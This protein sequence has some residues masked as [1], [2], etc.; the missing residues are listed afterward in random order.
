MGKKIL[1]EK[2][3]VFRGFFSRIFLL[4]LF[5]HEDDARKFPFFFSWSNHNFHSDL[6]GNCPVIMLFFPFPAP[7]YSESLIQ[8]KIKWKWSGIGFN[9]KSSHFFNTFLASNILIVCSRFPIHFWRILPEKFPEPCKQN[10]KT[11]Q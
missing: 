11:K 3:S 8:K 10:E 9:N 6:S 2:C 4:D 7:F 5:H 1:H